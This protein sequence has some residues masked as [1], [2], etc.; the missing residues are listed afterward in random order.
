[1]GVVCLVVHEAEALGSRG[2]AM[3]NSV[4]HGL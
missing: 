3:A 4:V 2:N 1:M